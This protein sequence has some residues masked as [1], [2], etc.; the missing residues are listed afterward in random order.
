M[1][2]GVEGAPVS[3]DLTTNVLINNK[4]V[5]GAAYRWSAAVSALLGFQIYDGLFA[6]YGYD[7]ET[8][9]LENYNSGS[10][11]IFLRFE[12]FKNHNKITSP[13]FF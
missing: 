5:I 8:T 7:L 3:L 2:K 1:A 11:E 13:R 6:G 10:H 12:L 9:K 4:F